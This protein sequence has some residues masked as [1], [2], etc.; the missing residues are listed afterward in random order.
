M[1]KL[2][3]CTLAV[4]ASS[5]AEFFGGD[6]DDI[7]VE[8][9]AG[10]GDGR[11]LLLVFTVQDGFSIDKLTALAADLPDFETFARRAFEM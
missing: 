5:G 9:T 8:L 4:F 6:F 3:D 11:E 7:C 2:S 10:R 1:I